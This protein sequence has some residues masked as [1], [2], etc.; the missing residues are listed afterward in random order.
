MLIQQQLMFRR[1]V[2][3]PPLAQHMMFMEGTLLKLLS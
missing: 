2:V 1:T 3:G